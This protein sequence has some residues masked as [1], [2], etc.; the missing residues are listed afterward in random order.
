M[1]NRN[2]LFLVISLFISSCSWFLGVK[3]L[4]NRIYWDD[5]IIVVAEH[6]NYQG[7]G[8]CI[9]PRTVEKAE[10]DGNFILVRTKN[11]QNIA[12]YWVIDKTTTLTQVKYIPE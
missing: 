8:K 10:K 7:I 3:K 12:Q 2:Y 9:I 4:G 1:I 11:R 6:D 5:K